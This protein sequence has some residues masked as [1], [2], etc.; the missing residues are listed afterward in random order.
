MGQTCSSCL[1]S[2]GSDTPK[3]QEYEDQERQSK[4]SLISSNA[5]IKHSFH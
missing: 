5:E 3:S 4:Y 1:S 2:S